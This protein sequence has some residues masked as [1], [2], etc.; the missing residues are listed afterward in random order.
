MITENE[1]SLLTAILN[2][3][4]HDGQPPLEITFGSTALM[5][6]AIPKNSQARWRAL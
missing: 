1:R 3:E 2:S 5:A 4:F 6:G